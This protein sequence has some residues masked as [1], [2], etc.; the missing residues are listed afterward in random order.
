L[1]VALLALRGGA[2]KMHTGTKSRQ[3][4]KV[5]NAELEIA[6]PGK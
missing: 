6:G 1:A 2:L 5:E 3:S 4:H